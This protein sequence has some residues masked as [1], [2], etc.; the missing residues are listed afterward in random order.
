MSFW[1][2]YFSS[3]GII[4]EFL[5]LIG[6]IVALTTTNPTPQKTL[7][8]N[9]ISIKENVTNLQL[10]CLKNQEIHTLVPLMDWQ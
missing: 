7:F 6:G 10:S 5:P 3:C 4:C 9:V 1:V 2:Q 8:T